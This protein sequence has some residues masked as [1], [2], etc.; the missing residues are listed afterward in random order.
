MKIAAT[1]VVIDVHLNEQGMFVLVEFLSFTKYI[2]APHIISYIY[3]VLSTYINS[4]FNVAIIMMYTS[5]KFKKNL[6]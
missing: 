4:G 5:I 6:T 3:D 1:I 2:Y